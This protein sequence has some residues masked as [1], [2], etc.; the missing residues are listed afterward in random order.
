M[1]KLPRSAIRP[2]PVQYVAQWTMKDGEQVTIRPIRPEDE[3]ADDRV[4]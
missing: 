1:S 4:P 3:P 2:Y